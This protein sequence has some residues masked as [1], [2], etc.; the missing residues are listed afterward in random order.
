MAHAGRWGEFDDAIRR[1]A[2]V[3]GRLPP[4]PMEDGKLGAGFVEWMMMVPNGWVTDI[5]DKRTL[6]LRLLG[7]AVVPVQAAFALGQLA[8]P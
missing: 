3:L 5:V 2:E 1:H 8:R 4:D 7:N 6:C